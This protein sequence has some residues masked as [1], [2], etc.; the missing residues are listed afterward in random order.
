MVCASIWIFA[1]MMIT[2]CRLRPNAFEEVCLLQKSVFGDRSGTVFPLPLSPQEAA[3]G[4]S[5]SG[6]YDQ[7]RYLWTDAFGVVNYVSQAMISSSPAE[8]DS[9]IFSAK[10]LLDATL[11]CLGNPRSESKELQSSMR[12]DTESSVTPHIGLRIGKVEHSIAGSDAGM[13]FDG[14]YFHYFDKILFAMLR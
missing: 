8:K 11:L 10:S 5:S 2:K 14:M 6:H 12:K 13:R 9:N 1:A 7:R 3:S 4:L